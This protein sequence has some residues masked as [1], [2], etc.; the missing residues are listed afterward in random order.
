MKARIKPHNRG[1]LVKVRSLPQYP[2]PLGLS[3]SEE[4]VI[5]E[6]RQGIRVVADRGGTLHELPVV[7][8]VSGLEYRYNEE[9]LPPSHPAVERRLATGK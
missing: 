7:C 2:L 8:V 3:E 9:W 4:V 1:D 6:I 5:Q